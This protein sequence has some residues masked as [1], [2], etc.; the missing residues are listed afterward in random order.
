MS[1][2]PVPPPYEDVAAAFSAPLARLARGYEADADRQRDLLQEVHLALWRGLPGFDGRASLRTWVYRVAHNVALTHV[3]KGARRR[4]EQCIPIEDL[5]RMA[6]GDA[7]RS[8]ED[9]DQ[10]ARLADLVRQLRPAD[11]QVILLYLEGFDHGEIAEI[12]GISPENAATKVHRIKR[13][14]SAA[15]GRGGDHGA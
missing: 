11:R 15:L 7:A 6:A 4:V 10:V 12:A 5:E 1:P 2:L 3:A 8:L 9:R 13:A 14:L